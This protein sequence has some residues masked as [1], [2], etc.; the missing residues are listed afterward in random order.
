[1]VYYLDHYEGFS[2]G[3]EYLGDDF[4]Q[5]TTFSQN[6]NKKILINTQ[7]ASGATNSKTKILDWKTWQWTDQPTLNFEGF[8]K[9][10]LITFNNE[11]YAIGLN[12]T[13][14][15][16]Y[17]ALANQWEKT[18]LSMKHPRKYFTTM[19]IPDDLTNCSKKV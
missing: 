5:C 13:E 9:H 3:P 2:E 7:L 17:D 14:I 8:G 4:L 16:K 11:P 12:G 1:M 6:G 18:E 19:L 10:S 15:W